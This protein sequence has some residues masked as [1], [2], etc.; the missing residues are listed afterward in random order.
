M[1]T[2]IA[3][4]T[5]RCGFLCSPLTFPGQ[6]DPANQNQASKTR[7]IFPVQFNQ[8]DPRKLKA[9]RSEAVSHAAAKL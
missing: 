2:K 7:L 3:V 4:G 9:M 5:V 6:V 1:Q 8:E